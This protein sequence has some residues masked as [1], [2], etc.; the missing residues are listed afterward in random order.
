MSTNQTI[1]KCETLVKLSSCYLLVGM[2][3][4][5]KRNSLKG[6]KKITGYT[7]IVMNLQNLFFSLNWFLS[8]SF[9]YRPRTVDINPSTD[10]EVTEK[11]IRYNFPVR[12][13]FR[14]SIRETFNSKTQSRMQ[15]ASSNSNNNKREITNPIH[16]LFSKT[17]HFIASMA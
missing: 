16:C 15:S 4:H 7:S 17:L 8:A 11:N 5:S 3:I 10:A 1:I 14:P 12:L 9:C 2:Y 6:K 13:V